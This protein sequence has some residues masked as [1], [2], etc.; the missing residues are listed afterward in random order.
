MDHTTLFLCLVPAFLM[1]GMVL[2]QVWQNRTLTTTL[3]RMSEAVI[4]AHNVAGNPQAGAIM[5]QM[6][7][8]LALEKEKKTV[9]DILR[10]KADLNKRA[11]QRPE[12]PRR[13]PM[14]LRPTDQPTMPFIPISPQPVLSPRGETSERNES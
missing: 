13:A 9:A 2:L 8:R 10:H 7:G 4:S 1:C 5:E 11:V 3:V 14:T 12:L 6:K